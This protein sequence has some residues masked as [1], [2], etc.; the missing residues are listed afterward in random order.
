MSKI[1]QPQKGRGA[2]SRQSGRFESLQREPVDIQWPGDHVISNNRTD[3]QLEQA[4]RIITY[5]SSPDVPFDRSIN[6]YQGCEHGCIYC[7]ARPSHAYWGLSPGL[8]FEQQLFAKSNAAELLEKELLNRNY[9]P[10]AIA[11]GANTDAYQPIERHQHI[12]RR[13]LQVLQKFRHPT[14][15]ITKSALVERDI[16]ILAEMS[17]QNLVRVII[18]ITTLDKDL[19]QNMEPRASSPSRRLETLERLSDAGVSTGLLMAPII[20]SLN[21]AEIEN[22]LTSGRDAGASTAAYVFLRLPLELKT[23]FTQWLEQHYPLKK[24]RILQQ[25][26]TS[27]EGKLYSNNFGERMTGSGPIADMIAQR[28]SL[29]QKRLGLDKLQEELDCSLFDRRA[30][31][32]QLSLF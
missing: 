4:K 12:T 3:V 25:L 11:L 10:S 27:R 1:Q 18:S 14:V 29:A 24:N 20:P 6:P 22:I 31:D 13:V 21:C 23:L 19:A 32:R 16:D 26:I 15:I 8:D 2:L 7:F 9:S 30:N 5:N 28:F 17:A